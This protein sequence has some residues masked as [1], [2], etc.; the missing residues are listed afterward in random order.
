VKTLPLLPI[1]LL[2]L[3]AIATGALLWQLRDQSRPTELLGPPRADYRL[4]VFELIALDADGRESFQARGP[5]LDRHPQLGTI[6]IEQPR[7]VIPDQ[8]G[9][10]W[11]ARSRRA[12][13]SRDGNELQ[14]HGAVVLLGPQES[15]AAPIRLETERL[16]VFPRENRVDT[17]L[18]VTGTEPGSILRGRG[19]RA[20]LDARRVELMSE[21][22]IRHE[23]PDRR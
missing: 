23:P 4:E 11:K 18:A 16:N 13:L 21:V 8:D 15:D 12:W 5:R 14:L 17:D 9:A 22:R 10:P 19:M 7:F 2:T 3:L 1:L 20:D 6:D